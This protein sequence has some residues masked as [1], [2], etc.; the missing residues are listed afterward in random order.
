MLCANAYFIKHLDETWSGSFAFIGE[1]CLNVESL[2]LPDMYTFNLVSPNGCKHLCDRVFSDSCSLIF[3]DVVEQVCYLTQPY[4]V[5]LV[6][7][8]PPCQFVEVYRRKRLSGKT[9]C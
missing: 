1:S 9:V 7:K 6:G 5:V 3:Y 4:A 2:A 8:E